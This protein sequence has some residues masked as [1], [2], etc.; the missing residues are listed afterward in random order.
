MQ[1]VAVDL[2]AMG[3]RARSA[4][5]RLATLSTEAKN[6]ALSNIA[7]GLASRQ[8]EILSANESDCE[9]AGRDGMSA[10]SLDRLVL[11]PGRLGGWHGTSCPSHPSRIR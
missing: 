8:D 7:D 11:D 2:R 9:R 4:S 10:A 1:A 6:E 3:R 5:H